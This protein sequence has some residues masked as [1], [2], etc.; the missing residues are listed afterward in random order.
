MNFFWTN[1]IWYVLLGLVTLFQLIFVMIKAKRRYLTIALYITILGMTLNFESI[2]FIFMKAYDYYPMIIQSSPFDDK[3]AGS[4]FSEWFRIC[5][6]AFDCNS[7]FK[8]L[9][10]FYLCVDMRHH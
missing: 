2:I 5:N 1:T 10:V 9:L 3:L 6:G 4:L 7:G 8:I